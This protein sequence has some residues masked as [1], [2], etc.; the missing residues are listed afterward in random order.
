MEGERTLRVHVHGRVQGVAFRAY[1]CETARHLGLR[2][3][4]RNHRTGRTVELLI[5]GPAGEVERF[6]RWL[7]D[8]P[9]LADVERVDVAEEAPDDVPAGRFEIARSV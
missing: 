4:V 1:A 7:H 3:W 6:V 8:G 9:P 2:G 5:A